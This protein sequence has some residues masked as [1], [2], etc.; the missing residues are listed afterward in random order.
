MG[1]KQVRQGR[2]KLLGVGEIGV[3]RSALQDPRFSHPGEVPGTC[4]S[5]IHLR[6]RLKSVHNF[7][8]EARRV[9]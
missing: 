9:G 1:E 4:P 8:A 7:G 5:P 3:M 6:G 2:A